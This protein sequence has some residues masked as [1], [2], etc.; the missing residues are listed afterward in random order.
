MASRQRIQETL[1]DFMDKAKYTV[2]EGADYF[3][4]WADPKGTPQPIPAGGVMRSTGY[5]HYGP[6]EVWLDEKKGGCVL[7]W[8]WLGVRFLKNSYSWQVYKECIPLVTTPKR[9][10]V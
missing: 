7:H 5:T 6:C 9:L 4:G 2:I 8:Y 1:R 10:R 3:C